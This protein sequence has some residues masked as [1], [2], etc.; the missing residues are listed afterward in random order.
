[1]NN[2]LYDVRCKFVELMNNDELSEEEYNELG[3]ELALELK[4]KSANIIAY[5]VDSEIVTG[6]KIVN[7][8]TSLRIR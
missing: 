6:T 7:D 1:M 5:I 2:T 4:N 8:K 3:K